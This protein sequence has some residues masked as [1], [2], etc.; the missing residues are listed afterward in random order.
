MHLNVVPVPRRLACPVWIAAI[1]VAWL[2][3]I[4]FISYTEPATQLCHFKRLTSVPC[5]SCGMT[6]GVKSILAGHPL[7][8]LAFNPFWMILLGTLIGLLGLKMIFGRGIQVAWKTPGERRT[9]WGVG[10]TLLLVNWVYVIV[11]VH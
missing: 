2:G 4:A 7:R 10:I 9:A 5:P 11:Y 8:G 6:R 1:V 3:M